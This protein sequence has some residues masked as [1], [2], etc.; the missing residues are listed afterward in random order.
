MEVTRTERGWAG[1]YICA[2]RCHFRRNTLLECED[3]RIVISTVGRMQ[4][5]D[6][7]E[8]GA[9]A[10]A[11]G[12]EPIGAFDRHFET[13]VFHAEWDG[14]YWDVNVGSQLDFDSEWAISGEV[15]H[16]SDQK[17]NDMHE[18]VVAEITGK[19]ERGEI[20]PTTNSD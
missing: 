3:I 11:T 12:N 9:Y 6:I 4:K 10:P 15:E 18:A 16:D 1:H 20:A 5:W 13:M 17:A 14:T 19:L 7:N 2:D 8:R